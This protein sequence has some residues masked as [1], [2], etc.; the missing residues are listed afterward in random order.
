[1]TTLAAVVTMTTP[2]AIATDTCRAVVVMD[3]PKGVVATNIL[4]HAKPATPM[5]IK[6]VQRAIQM[7]EYVTVIQITCHE[8]E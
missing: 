7:R 5:Q 1:M 4:K 3:I 6:L 2:P 8:K